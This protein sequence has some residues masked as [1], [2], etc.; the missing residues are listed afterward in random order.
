MPSGVIID[1]LSVF[2][3]GI[4]GELAGNFISEDFKKVMN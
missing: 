1:C 2:L 3:G 4:F